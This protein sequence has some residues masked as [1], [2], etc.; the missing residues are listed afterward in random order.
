M[1]IL[2]TSAGR[3][4]YLLEYFKKELKNG[5]IHAANS[6]YIAPAFSVADKSV[7][8]PLIYDENYIPFLLEY[9]KNNGINMVISLLDI[10]LMIL[11]KNKGKFRKIGVEVV[12]SNEDVINICN[13]KWKTYQFLLKNELDAPKTYIDFD[14]AS[15][16]LEQGEIKYPVIIK[17]RWGMGSIG[18]YKA[19]NSLELKVLYDKITKEIFDTVLKYESV[20]DKNK[21]VIIQE[22]L[23]GQEHGL[24]IINDLEGNYQTTIVKKKIAMRSG[25]TDCALTIKDEKI[26][27]IGK[28]ISKTLRHIANLDVD[29]FVDGDN[30]YVLEMNARFGGGYPFGHVAG[31]NLPKALIHWANKEEIEKDIFEYEEMMVH[32][33]IRLIEIKREK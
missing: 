1:N 25:E 29:I 3:R 20:E 28:K 5:E 24:D 10:D 27:S 19:C 31:V 16:A 4:T 22:T 32:K 17:P 8:T 9:C 12:V 23:P 18:I 21:C 11:A 14:M 30:I 2:F 15:K 13:D 33:D 7:V 6:T 26:Q